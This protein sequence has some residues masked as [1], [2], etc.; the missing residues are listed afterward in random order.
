MEQYM[1]RRIVFDK[2]VIAKRVGELGKEISESYG[3]EPLVCICVLKG[4]Y[5]F[6]ADLM[7]SLTIDPEM[8][9][10]R[11]ASYAGGTSRGNKMIFSK[12]IEVSIENKHVLIVED[13]VD[14]GHSMKYLTQ[15]LMARN[16]RSIRIASLVDKNE[17]REID[18]TVDFT[19]FTLDKGFIMGYGLDY[20]EKYRGLDAVYELIQKP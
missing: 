10:V 8:D 20:D 19:G 14:T 5:V 1:E 18:V 3:D 13:I 16:P 4:A 9:F 7:R 2:D 17:R 15:V 6:F 12:D 11:L